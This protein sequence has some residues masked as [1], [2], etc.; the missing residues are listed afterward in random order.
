MKIE[1]DLISKAATLLREG[2]V[3]AFPTETVYGLGAD[4]TNELAIRKI[5][6]LKGRPTDHPLIVHLSNI[7]QVTEW[8]KEVSPEAL[9]LAKTFW[10]GPL[11]IVLKKQPHVLSAIT[12]G[13]DTVALRVPNHPLALALLH[14]FGGGLVA[15]SA[16]KFTRISPTTAIAVQEE[17]GEEVGL[18]LD[19]GPCEVG[20]ESTI[21]DMSVAKPVILRPGHISA[22]MIKAVLGRPVAIRS[23]EKITTRVPGS[24]HVHYAPITKTTLIAPNDI[25]PFLE[26][27]QSKDLPIGLLMY[28]HLDLIKTQHPDVYYVKMASDPA[29]YAH[30]LYRTLRAMD[31]QHYKHILIEAVPKGIAW[32]AIRDRLIKAT[33][34]TL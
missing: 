21:I 26:T 5:Y 18:V 1:T 3:V 2:N 22:D 29:Q 10:P 15:P 12:G 23:Q 11:T 6:Q 16:N 31:H 30:E 13:Q 28:S 24:H 20:I 4:A 9:Q 17:F 8:A 25:A 34:S 7:Q 27:L 19:G 33:G 14:S 32:D